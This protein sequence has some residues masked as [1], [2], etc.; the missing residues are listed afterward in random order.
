MKRI[1]SFIILAF[2]LTGCAAQT[3]T[4]KANANEKDYKTLITDTNELMAMFEDVYK[5][6]REYTAKEKMAVTEYEA[7]YGK[8][9][10][11]KG[12]SDVNVKLI[13][14]MTLMLSYEAKKQSGVEDTFARD[15]AALKRDI[16]YVESKK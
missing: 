13:S 10:D 11:F 14:T 1:I 16:A 4:K 8:D 7:N 5:E 9:S 12:N 6:G 15:L 2:V 3:S